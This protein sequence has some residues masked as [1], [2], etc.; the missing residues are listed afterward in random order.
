MEGLDRTH[1]FLGVLDS[2]LGFDNSVLLLKITFG[3][4]P[5]LTLRLAGGAAAGVGAGAGALGLGEGVVAIF[6]SP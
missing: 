4:P 3:G 6:V 5:G 2:M 1:G